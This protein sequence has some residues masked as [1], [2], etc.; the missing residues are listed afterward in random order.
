MQ[1]SA[2]P[3]SV[4][5]QSA[6]PPFSCGVFKKTKVN[7]APCKHHARGL[8]ASHVQQALQI[9]ANLLLKHGGCSLLKAND[10]EICASH[11]C[12]NSDNR[13]A[14]CACACLVVSR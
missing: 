13:A 5:L 8:S 4:V 7:K 12:M 10:P 9:L 3:S 6:L 14:P 1:N 11:L 2:L